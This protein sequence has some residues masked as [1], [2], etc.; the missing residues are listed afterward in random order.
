MS[1]KLPPEVQ[2]QIIGLFLFHT[3]FLMSSCHVF[4]ISAIATSVYFVIGTISKCIIF[5]GIS[6]F[7]LMMVRLRH[8]NICSTYQQITSMN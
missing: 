8:Q 7:W 3:Y 4:Q 5:L 2:T 1:L 6:K